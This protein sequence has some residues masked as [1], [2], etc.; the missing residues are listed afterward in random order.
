M[1]QAQDQAQDQ[2]QIDKL[3]KDYQEAKHDTTRVQILLSLRNNY[4]N[5][6]PDST[7]A[8]AE[9]M[10]T[11]AER[12]NYEVGKVDALSSFGIG[13]FTK[14]E[15]AKGIEYMQQALSIAQKAK[16]KSE[17]A[18][19]YSTLGSIKNAENNYVLALEYF[20]K[21]LK[22]HEELNNNQLGTASILHNIG[23]V[24]SIQEDYPKALY[25]FQKSLN[26]RKEI[27]D[28]QG[29]VLS[30]RELALIHQNQGKYDLAL[31]Y[32]EQILGFKEIIAS[33]QEAI[34]QAN[35]GFIYTKQAKYD[36][37][38][39]YLEKARQTQEKLNDF[40]HLAYVCDKLAKLFIAQNKYQEAL[41]YAKKGMELA[42]REES[43]NLPLIQELAQT[44]AKAYKGNEQYKEALEY[45]ELF[46]QIQDSL[47]TLDKTKTIAN[48]ES[49]IEINSL[50]VE[51]EKQRS[52]NAAQ[53]T[54]MYVISIGLLIALLLA[55]FAYRSRQA[56]KHAKE[57]I[58][59]Q[60]EEITIQ[61]EQLNT[62]N[63]TKDQLFA[64]IAHDLRN[65]ITAFQGIT[66][67]INFF[68]RKNKP[69]RLLQMTESIDDSVRHINHLLNN[70][71][72]WALTQT[73]QISLEKTQTNLFENTEEA[74]KIYEMSALINQIEL[75]NTLSKEISVYVDKDSFQTILRNLLGNAIKYTPENGKIT[76]SAKPQNDK[77][78]LS[79]TDTGTG[80]NQETKQKISQLSV[81][82]TKRGL[83]G[84]KGTGL[85]L[86]LCYEFAELNN[87]KIDIESK[88]NEGTTFI[89]EI[90]TKA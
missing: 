61:A 86:V 70:L 16:L 24:F 49:K 27:N 59:A 57:Q 48:L 81:G 65:P 23:H 40:Y 8:I 84:E 21:A 69:E 77:I 12:S 72:N 29:I 13:Y 66:E 45:H 58:N 53:L 54:T 85:G 50:S 38:A 37:A 60:K 56:E 28:Q 15:K 83:R 44:L 42:Q 63:K 80:M 3:R 82:N 17:V 2:A 18:N 68:L 31:S 79:I 14:G 52:I 78:I 32:Y 19:C 39:L 67:Q 88:E 34:V 51:A 75:K 76:L 41:D 22:T 11:L 10:Y 71:L 1:T 73:N 20:Q 43:Q 36:S 33:K 4:I 87:I 30:L 35:M 74:I 7:I 64:I 9:R 62:A 89:L 6:Y 25:Y 47:F 26:L 90:P 5:D 46:K 55:Y